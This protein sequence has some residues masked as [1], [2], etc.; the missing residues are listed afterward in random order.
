MIMYL[1]SGNKNKLKEIK[2]IFKE[3]PVEIELWDKEIEETGQ[4]FLENAS[5]KALEASKNVDSLVMADDSGLVV[6]ALNGAPGIYSARYAPTPAERIER[7]LNEM[8]D[9]K[10]DCRQAHFACAVVLAENNRIL[11]EAEEKCEGSINYSP[12]GT[13]GF[14]YDPIFYLPQFNQ[15]MAQIDEGLK[16]KISHRGKAFDKLKIFL[17]EKYFNRK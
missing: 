14:G 6:Q 13:N 8:K 3:L 5:L 7:L 1:A 11:F 15:T 16:N 4:T 17:I 12:E 10:E 9:V 2:E